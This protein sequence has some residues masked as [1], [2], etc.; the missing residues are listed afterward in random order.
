M[1]LLGRYFTFATYEVTACSCVRA[2]TRF[3][4]AVA[5]GS[6]RVIGCACGRQRTRIAISIVSRGRM[7]FR[8][9]RTSALTATG[10]DSRASRIQR[11]LSKSGLT[12]RRVLTIH[13]V[14][15]FPISLYNMLYKH[16][17]VFYLLARGHDAVQ[18][19]RRRPRRGRS[20]KA[21]IGPR[22]GRRRNPSGT[23][24]TREIS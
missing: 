24:C 19:R 22:F 23:T 21:P 12:G 9:R 17:Y 20:K 5:S 1:R 4:L 18:C 8:R 16:D 11:R 10:Q 15:V 13:L 3:I 6:L 14:Y 2:C 7:G